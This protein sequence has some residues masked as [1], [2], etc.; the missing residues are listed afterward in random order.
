MAKRVRGLDRNGQRSRARALYP[1]RRWKHE[2]AHRAPMIGVVAWLGVAA[3]SVSGPPA[4][5]GS[6]SGPVP[7]TVQTETPSPTA[8]PSPTPTF[9]PRFRRIDL[10]ASRRRVEVGR[11]VVFS[12]EI[13]ANRPDCMIDKPVTVRRL[14][15]GT[16]KR[17]PVANRRTDQRGR[18]RVAERARWSSAYTAVAHRRE[19]CR[20]EV[21]DPVVVYVRARLGIRVDDR[22]PSRFTNFRVFGR[23]RP[24]HRSTE[25]LLQR[26]GRR[27]WSRVQSQEL[28]GR[29]TYSFFPLADWRGKR[30]FRVKWPKADRDH[31]TGTSGPITIRTT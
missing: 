2:I 17:L 6:S 13:E 3:F 26:Q 5:A 1:P 22:T 30:V 25:V 23:L 7:L 19:G 9:D 21:S 12:G 16:S 11:R 4:A 31:E 28:S 29:S 27:G 14:I 20:R 8:S 15:F 10:S 18:F 24:S